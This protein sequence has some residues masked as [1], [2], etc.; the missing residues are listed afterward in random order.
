MTLISNSDGLQLAQ[1]DENYLR[2]EK[3]YGKTHF[4]EPIWGV[5]PYL[6]DLLP[7]QSVVAGGK[8]YHFRLTKKLNGLEKACG[9][10]KL[11]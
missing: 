11:D 7:G 8:H 5:R 4:I 10:D 9:K 1:D 6:P 2:V 3:L